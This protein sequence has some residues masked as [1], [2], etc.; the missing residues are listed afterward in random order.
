MMPAACGTD[1]ST[2]DTG[3]TS[4]AGLT[5]SFKSSC[6]G[7]HG[8]GGAGGSGPSLLGFS[9]SKASFTSQVRN[10][11]GGMPAFPATQY[12]DDDLTIDFTYLISN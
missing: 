8:N 2:N 4:A 5:D 9:R 11:G 1:D 6:A 10:G 3:G 12:S 7:C